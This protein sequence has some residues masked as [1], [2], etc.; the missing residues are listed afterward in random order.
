MTARP[1]LI[2]VD[3]GTT[4]CRAYLIAPDGVSAQAAGAGILGIADQA[5]AAALAAMIAPWREAHGALPILLSGMIGSRQGWREVPY[6]AC[7]A[8][9]P[10]LAA[11][12]GRI[13]D[14]A[15]GAVH[16]VPGL[17]VTHGEMPDVMRG[18]ETQVIGALAGGA[19]LFVLPGTHSK[20]VEVADG[21]ITSFRTFMTGEVYGA[22]KEH[23]ILG[24]LMQPQSAVDSQ[25]F[26]RGVAEGAAQESGGALLHRLFAARTYGLF[27]R[28][29]AAGLADYLSGL[30]IGAEI[31]EATR[32]IPDRPIT[33]LGSAALAERYVAAFALLG[34]AAAFGPPDCAATGHYR[35]A[36]AAG[37]VGDA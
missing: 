3:W 17:T 31:A 6:L 37:L 9:T 32:A 10:D 33:I 29:P 7:P 36:Q 15:L 24:R 5:F 25:A 30:L 22:L 21:R 1:C 14:A 4:A 11:A 18:E 2:G 27:D 8:G 26:S 20:W 12:L 19:G 34:R 13:D 16:V 23:T 35:L 28:V